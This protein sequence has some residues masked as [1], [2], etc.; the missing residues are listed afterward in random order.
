[1]FVVD[2]LASTQSHT[3]PHTRTHRLISLM[4]QLSLLLLLSLHN[5]L[6]VHQV[7]ALIHSEGALWG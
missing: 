3:Q 5:P 2:I 4:Q 6:Q 7:S 1:M